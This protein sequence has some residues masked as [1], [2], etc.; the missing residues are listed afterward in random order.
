MNAD[1]VLGSRGIS[2][3]SD[4]LTNTVTLTGAVTTEE[5]KARAGLIAV[6]AYPGGQVRNQLEV[7]QRL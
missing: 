6:E 2:V 3:V 5:E 7:R 4:E 1:P